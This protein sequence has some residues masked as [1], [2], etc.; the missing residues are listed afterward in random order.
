M[1]CEQTLPIIVT[2]E[3]TR[4]WRSKVGE[5]CSSLPVSSS[6]RSSNQ[7]LLP[8]DR[9]MVLSLQCGISYP[10]QLRAAK[11]TLERPKRRL[12]TRLK[13]HRYAVAVLWGGG[14]GLHHPPPP[15]T[16]PERDEHGAL[17]RHVPGQAQPSLR[18]CLHPGTMH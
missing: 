14:G 2:T 4:H 18:H 1:K 3:D 13:E 5:N 15:Q 17:A 11:S 8:V 10:L 7:G 9:V 6:Q 16:T 12:E